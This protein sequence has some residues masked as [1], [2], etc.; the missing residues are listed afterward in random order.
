MVPY[1]KSGPCP[2]ALLRSTKHK[3]VLG[4]RESFPSP[5]GRQVTCF[6]GSER[7]LNGLGSWYKFKAKP[8]EVYRL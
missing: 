3:G 8:A 1:T 5:L 2:H 4:K 6:K 7:F